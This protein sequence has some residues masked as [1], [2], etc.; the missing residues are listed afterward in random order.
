MKVPR[1]KCAYYAAPGG[2]VCLMHDLTSFTSEAE[3]K[4]RALTP[5]EAEARGIATEV[6]VTASR[7]TAA[8]ICA[9]AER[10]GADNMCIDSHTRPG[11]TAKVLGS[12]ALAV[13]QTSRRPVLVV[14]PPTD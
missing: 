6:E 11:F 1:L 3:A 10:F 2:T 8:A 7:E 14:R 13:L 9:A 12:L 5:H 4:L